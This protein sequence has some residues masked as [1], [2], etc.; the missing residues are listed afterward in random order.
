M[1]KITDPL[2]DVGGIPHYQ[3]DVPE[4]EGKSCRILVQKKIIDLVP[5]EQQA[6]KLEDIILH[7]MEYLWDPRAD[8][9]CRNYGA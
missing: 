8:E 9:D 6:Q 3:V 4:G 5:E 1:R 2:I 7:H